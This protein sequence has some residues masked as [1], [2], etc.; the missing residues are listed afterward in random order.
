MLIGRL[1]S[2]DGPKDT[3]YK[4]ASGASGSSNIAVTLV[5]LLIAIIAVAYYFLFANK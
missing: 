4:M 1:V 3:V 2:Y 5:P